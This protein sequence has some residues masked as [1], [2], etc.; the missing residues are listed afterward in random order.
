M[1]NAQAAGIGDISD[2]LGEQRDEIS[3]SDM[4]PI[5]KRI[6]FRPIDDISE[7]I[8]MYSNGVL[9]DD[10]LLEKLKKRIE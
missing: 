2:A 7:D 6:A 4:S 10:A 9:D 5:K 1:S 8:Q 3:A